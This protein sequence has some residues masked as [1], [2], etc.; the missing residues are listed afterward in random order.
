MRYLK[1]AGLCA[2]G[3]FTEF[4]LSV[5]YSAF[6][7]LLML[8][9][10]AAIPCCILSGKTHAYYTE[11]IRNDLHMPLVMYCIIALVLPVLVGAAGVYI[12][13]AMPETIAPNINSMEGSYAGFAKLLIFT[14]VLVNA[15][16]IT[17][18]GVYNVYKERIT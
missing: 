6:I 17:A 10:V 18:S 5:V 7:T 4:L 2:A 15:I 13:V 3:F 8:N 14:A 12:N 11:R 16:I 9:P 1:Y